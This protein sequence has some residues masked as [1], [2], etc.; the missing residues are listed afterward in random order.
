MVGALVD[1]GSSVS[2]V[3]V[4]DA[5]LLRASGQPFVHHLGQGHCGFTPNQGGAP[6]GVGSGVTG[7]R[8][9]AELAMCA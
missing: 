8:I 4:H 7:A 9:A 2:S 5:G 1:I 3:R 6:Q